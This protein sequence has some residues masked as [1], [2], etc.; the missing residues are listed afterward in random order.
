[1]I[2][3]N[4]LQPFLA[5]SSLAVAA[6]PVPPPPLPILAL[7]HYLELTPVQREAI[8]R[9]LDGGRQ[10]MEAKRFAVQQGQRALHAALADPASGEA[11]VKALCAQDA[12]ARLEE[13][14]E[15]HAHFKQALALL[16][17]AQKAKLQK[18]QAEMPLIQEI[19][20]H[21][22]GP[23]GQGRQGGPGGADRLGGSERPGPGGEWPPAPGT[24]G[25]PARD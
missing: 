9:L 19:M 4:P 16:T 2:T 11:Q 18:A 14:L 8:H 17:P 13:A 5:L 6:Q 10:T 21:R 7:G 3:R 1:M 12:Q 15:L 24:S 23:G 20:G 25:R 22:G